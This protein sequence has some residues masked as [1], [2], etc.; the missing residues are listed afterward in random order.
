MSVAFWALLL[1]LL[2]IVMVLAG[3]LLPR[4]FV[5]SAM[6]YL[7]VGYLLGPQVLGLI[8]LDPIRDAGVLGQAAEVAVLISLFA[9]G[10]KLGSTPLRDARWRP[11]LRLASACMVLSV[12]L[13]T[14]AGV[15]GLGLSLGA[16]VLLGA[17]LAP[18]DPVLA[19]GVQAGP[20]VDTDR[21][22]FSLAGE[23]GLNDGTAFPFVMLGL[24]L[25]GLHELGS[26]G[27]RWW[28]MDLAWPT[29][30]GLL[31]GAVLG[32][33]LGKLVVHLRTRH[34]QA[35]GLDEFLSLGL[36]AVAYGGAQ[37]LSGYGFLAVFA[38]GLALQRVREQPQVGTR[39]LARTSDPGGH[40]YEMRAAHSHHASE[41][42]SDA[43]RGF[44]EQLEKLAEMGI[45][46]L[47]GAMLSYATPSMALWWFVPLLFV[48]LRPLAVSAGLA[49][50]A[51]S[52]PQR[53]M[54]CWFGIRGIGSMFYLMFAI[55]HGLSEALAQQL[56]TITL[57]T[58]AASVVVHG[59]SVRPLM[60]LYRLRKI[61]AA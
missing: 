37:L 44:N 14:A 2:L 4:L 26:G 7:G 5:S 36:I 24:G 42:M 18:T 50:E 8:A 32:A 60:R 48:V 47:V 51:M 25:L 21:L 38:A 57:V 58:I 1:G 33:L 45:V 30:A 46:L 31:V 35:M 52:M 55:E 15:W 41:A 61:R 34:H 27:W 17:I 54:I 29:A 59:V 40:S 23:G 11:P 10:L 56:L 43:V 13:V 12:G 49:G 20:A 19:S 28:L 6:I 9:V 22:R 3:T 16:A 53:A 39:S